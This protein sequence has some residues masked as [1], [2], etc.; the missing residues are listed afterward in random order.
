MFLKKS[1][2]YILFFFFSTEILSDNVQRVL[3]AS[4]DKPDVEILYRL[5]QEINENTKVIFIMDRR[6]N[7]IVEKL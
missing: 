6:K 7:M 3:Y 4:W 2:I 5:P 1:L